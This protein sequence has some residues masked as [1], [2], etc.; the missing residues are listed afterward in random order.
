MSSI[1]SEPHSLF[2][3]AKVE[4]ACSGQNL[5]FLMGKRRFCL[6][7]GLGRGLK[8]ASGSN[9]THPAHGAWPGHGKGDKGHLASQGPQTERV[10]SSSNAQSPLAVKALLQLKRER[11][12][13]E[14]ASHVSH[15]TCFP[16]D[17]NKILPNV[18]RKD[19]Q[20]LQ[21]PKVPSLL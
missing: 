18:T 11:E 6:H 8:M 10:T 12:M 21:E 3:M 14:R 13:E 15:G 5:S 4:P 17:E 19:V 16:K 9:T 7:R 20:S 2:F 1:I